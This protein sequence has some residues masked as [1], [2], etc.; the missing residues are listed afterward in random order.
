MDSPDR[1]LS[2]CLD[3]LHG[4]C[5]RKGPEEI[6][7][8]LS[9]TFGTYPDSWMYLHFVFHHFGPHD[10]KFGL[11]DPAWKGNGIRCDRRTMA[12]PI[13]SGGNTEIFRERRVWLGM[14][15]A[16]PYPGEK[17]DQR[18]GTVGFVLSDWAHHRFNATENQ[19]LKSGLESP[20]AASGIALFQ[21]LLWQ[22]ID[23]WSASWHLCLNYIDGLHEVK[24]CFLPRGEF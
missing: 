24:V 10:D 19:W 13:G 20:K 4:F 17:T 16:T 8:N 15:T 12:L 23:E 1:D 21:L 7:R 5:R 14:R 18:P 9:W 22:G 3:S 2:W 11:D 6:D